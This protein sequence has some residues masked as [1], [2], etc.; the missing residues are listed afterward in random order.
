MT[1]LISDN[2]VD[3]LKALHAGKKRFGVMSEQPKYVKIISNLIEESETKELLDYGSGKQN[4]EK[5]FSKNGVSVTSY[6]PAIDALANNNI[7]KE[8]VICIDVLEHIEPDMLENVLADLHRCTLKK[9][10]FTISLRPAVKTLPDGR[11]AHLIIETSAWWKER[12]LKYFD[13][14]QEET[15]VGH[16]YEVFVTPKVK[17][18]KN[19]T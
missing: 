13:I 14:Q 9:G 3:Q 18:E 5:R 19:I 11:N 1:E 2:Y 16:S 6:E 15:R 8:I 4:T 10:F 7:P 17:D 12:L